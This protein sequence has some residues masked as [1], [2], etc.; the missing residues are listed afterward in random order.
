MIVAVLS[1]VHVTRTQIFLGLYRNDLNVLEARVWNSCL[2]TAIRI[3]MFKGLFARMQKCLGLHWHNVN[4]TG[5]FVKLYIP[6]DK[7]YDT[8]VKYFLFRVIIC[9]L[10]FLFLNFPHQFFS[11]QLRFCYKKL[12][13]V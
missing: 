12:Y 8:Q 10:F 9:H 3:Q 6:Y 11:L 5:V 13:W 7:I 4:K 1:I 2:G